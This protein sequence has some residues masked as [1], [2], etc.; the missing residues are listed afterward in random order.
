MLLLPFLTG[1]TTFGFGAGAIFFLRFWTRTRDELFLA[2]AA[3][4]LLLA[5]QAALAL[6]TIDVEG[7]AWIYLIRL[8]AFAIIIVA[9]VR[10]N[11]RQT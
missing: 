4:F 5:L 7:R 9:I 10:A 8:A 11:R 2:F 3:A 6:A 1:A